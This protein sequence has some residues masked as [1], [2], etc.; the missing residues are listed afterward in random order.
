[1]NSLPMTF[2]QHIETMMNLHYAGNIRLR[3]QLCFHLSIS[4]SNDFTYT[5]KQNGIALAEISARY[6][7]I[8]TMQQLGMM[9]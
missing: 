1:M 5:I 3:D 7:L 6:T 9:Q 4:L 2:N 8:K